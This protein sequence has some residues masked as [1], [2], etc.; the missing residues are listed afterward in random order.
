[1]NLLSNILFSKAIPPYIIYTVG[2]FDQENWYIVLN[3]VNIYCDYSF[4]C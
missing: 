2:M 1:M 4:N 3:R